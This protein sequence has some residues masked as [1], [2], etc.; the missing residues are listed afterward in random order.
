M[1]KENIE[2]ICHS[3]SLLIW[4]DIW[5]QR[6]TELNCQLQWTDF[7]SSRKSHGYVLPIAQFTSR[8]Q[9]SGLV[10]KFGETSERWGGV[11]LGFF[12][13]HRYDL[14]QKCT[15]AF[16]THSRLAYCSAARQLWEEGSSTGRG[17]RGHQTVWSFQVNT[18]S[19]RATNSCSCNERY[20][21]GPRNGQRVDQFRSLY[22][23][24][25]ANNSLQQK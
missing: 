14:K 2:T 12:Q 19:Q 6:G 5:Q 15:A 9:H 10:K 17:D 11:H 16:R 4:S 8:V 25:N 24:K 13:E 1:L 7:S 20:S 18:T 21:F 22:L 23:H 3:I